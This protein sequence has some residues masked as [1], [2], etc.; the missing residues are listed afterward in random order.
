VGGR[1]RRLIERHPYLPNA[2]AALAY[3]IGVVWRYLHIVHFHDPRKYVYSDM[4]MYVDLGRRLARP[5]YDPTILDVTHPP[6]M[7]TLIAEAVKLDPELSY[8][9][10]FQV[11]VSCL[12]PLGVMWFA[13]KAFDR[14]TARAA[15]ILS[16]IYFP[17]VEYGGYFLAEVYMMLLVPVTLALYLTAA[18]QKSRPRAALWGLAT[19]VALFGALAMKMVALPAIVGFATLHLLLAKTS[20]RSI[21]IIALGATLFAAA[22]GMTA[23]SARCTEANEGRFCLGS[24]KSAADFML[25]HY[26]RIQGVA[27]KPP[28]RRE[29]MSFGSPS[30]YQHGYREV[31]EVPFS[32]T[33]SEENSE[34]AW[35]WMRE[36][37]MHAVV[38]SFEHVFDMMGMTLPWPAVATG[39]WVGSQ[40]TQYLFLVFI[41]LP[42][43]YRLIDVWRERGLVELLRS[44]HF[45]VL[46]PILGVALA[47]FIATGEPRYRIP[48]DS[49]FMLLAIDFYRHFRRVRPEKDN[50]SGPMG[51]QA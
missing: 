51:A 29:V 17:F 30:A 20:P 47:V 48:F 18:E 50:E 39:Y 2:L 10:S 42:A 41:M 38:L 6:G 13:Y 31:P 26:G 49:V 19:G 37:K 11:L 33:D 46:S 12:V 3:V 15:L 5:D 7:S 27:W 40:G 43:F 36:H 9:V 45:T 22:P 44:R 24:N 34:A 25:G 8:L 21:R 23:I 1:L 14:T 16:S 28:D 32:I 4:K 35:K